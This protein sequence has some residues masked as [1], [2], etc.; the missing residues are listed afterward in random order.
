MYGIQRVT[1]DITILTKEEVILKQ[2]VKDKIEELDIA[3]LECE[4]DD[5]DIEEYKNDMEKAK[6][7]LLIRKNE[8]KELLEDK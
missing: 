7:K 5:N 8:L 3:I 2:K 6:R 4:Y 1:K